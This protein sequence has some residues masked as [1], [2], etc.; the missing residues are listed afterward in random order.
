MRQRDAA[1]PGSFDPTVQISTPNACQF[2]DRLCRPSGTKRSDSVLAISYEQIPLRRAM[3]A[4]H[5][6]VGACGRARRRIAAW[7][8]I[9]IG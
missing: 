1:G 7:D 3:K 5:R 9:E 6:T 8:T 4:D 2:A